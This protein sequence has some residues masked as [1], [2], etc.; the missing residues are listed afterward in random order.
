M[1]RLDELYLE[2]P[3]FGSR[4]FAVVLGREWRKRIS[5]K[6]MTTSDV[7]EER[8]LFFYPFFSETGAHELSGL[9]RS[10]FLNSSKVFGPKSFS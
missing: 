5:R 3:Y 10:I 7:S 4:K 2:L 6:R 9:K 8:I 1:R